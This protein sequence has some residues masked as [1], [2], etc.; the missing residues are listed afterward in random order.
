MHYTNTLRA[1][2]LQ[3]QFRVRLQQS[4]D[5]PGPAR[6]SPLRLTLIIGHIENTETIED[7]Q[8][9]DEKSHVQTQDTHNTQNSYQPPTRSPFQI[10]NLTS[11][12]GTS[13]YA[14]RATEIKRR[15]RMSKFFHT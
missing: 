1:I 3:S 7:T 11:T 4:L 15:F 6:T 14:R 13:L 5:M 9:R 2:G 12:H 8:E 10:E